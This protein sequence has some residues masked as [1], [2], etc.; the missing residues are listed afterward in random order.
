MYL[1]RLGREL[2]RR[3]TTTLL[4]LVAAF[5]LAGFFTFRVSHGG[6]HERAL[7]F[8]VAETQLMVDPRNSPLADSTV[9]TLDI[10]QLA[11]DYAEIIRTP[12]VVDPVARRLHIRP[13]QISASSQLIQDVP[14]TQSDALEAQRGVQIIDAG[15]HYSLLGR[16]DQST[17]VVQLF[18]QAPTGRQA[19][20]MATAAADALIAYAKRLVVTERI[21]RSRQ[22]R[23]VQVE[24]PYGGV[25][26]SSLAPE[27]VVLLTVVFF[28]LGMIA[29][30]TVA[31]WRRELV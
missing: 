26:D 8:G 27:A 24:Q 23:L 6:V 5:V 31:R 18:A 3:K 30:L 19:V 2:W 15:R 10:D 28:M 4:V 14:L 13:S 22:V 12:Q 21:P 7:S 25:V 20:T 1:A 9:L 17:F 16:V 11:S 29:V